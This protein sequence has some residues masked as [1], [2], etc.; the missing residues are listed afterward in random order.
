[1][2]LIKFS[3]LVCM[4]G[5]FF[6]C[7]VFGPW[8]ARL[9]VQAAVLL[10]VLLASLWRTTA[11]ETWGLV[12][13]CIP[14]VLTLL[15]FGLLFHL[16]RLLGRDDWLRDSLIK[17]LVFPSSLIFLKLLL[18]F[19]TYL[20]LLRL[21]I[22]TARR[23]DLITFKAALSKG[24]RIMA[25]FK[26]Y[27]DTYPGS[28]A[29]QPRKGALLRKYACLIMALYLYLYDEIETSRRVMENRMRFLSRPTDGGALE[30]SYPLI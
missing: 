19:V 25:R 27:L 18:T 20:D 11:R 7:L 21:P 23:V 16:F 29:G 8:Y 5:L 30:D 24:G 3:V 22:A 13:F 9:D 4:L 1:M 2:V 15:A 26:W 12:K 17:A 6:G 28:V 10:L 14:F